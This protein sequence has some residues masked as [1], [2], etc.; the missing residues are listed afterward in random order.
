MALSALMPLPP[1][2][3]GPLLQAG[4]YCVMA[5]AITLHLP[6]LAGLPLA[7]SVS[8]GLCAGAVM[9]SPYLAAIAVLLIFPAALLIGSRSP[10]L[11]KILSGWLAAVALLSVSLEYLPVSPGYLPDH[12]D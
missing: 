8:A 4:W 11:A 10:V 2:W 12:F 7:L 6:S 9:P 5:L 1:C 3:A